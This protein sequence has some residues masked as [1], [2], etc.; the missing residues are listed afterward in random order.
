MKSLLTVAALLFAALLVQ[1]YARTASL[2]DGTHLGTVEAVFVE[3][4]PGVFVPRS[5]ASAGES[6]PVW[7]HVRFADAL[8]DG[9]NIAVAALPPELPVALGDIVEMR[10]GNPA[11]GTDSQPVQNRVTARIAQRQPAGAPVH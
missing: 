5:T 7:V 4:Q 8:Q 1:A 9:R 6:T 2:S 11:D 10:F 3:S